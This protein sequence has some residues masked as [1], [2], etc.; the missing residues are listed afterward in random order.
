MDGKNLQCGSVS[1]IKTLKNPISAARV[2]MDKTAHNYLV[3][4]QAETFLKL[5]GLQGDEVENSYFYTKGRKDQLIAA[6][7]EGR[8]TLDH[9]G[10]E[11]GAKGNARM[12]KVCIHVGVY[13]TNI[14][15]LGTFVCM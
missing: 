3:G 8:V 14:C 4:Q 1:L 9:H 2:V 15:V 11:E 7:G 13:H 12:M 5:N 10:K 6:Q